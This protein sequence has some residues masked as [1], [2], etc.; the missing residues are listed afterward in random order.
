MVSAADFGF[1]PGSEADQ[2]AALQKAADAAAARGLPL[3][4]PGGTYRAGDINLTANVTIYGVDGAT[5]IINSGAAPIFHADGQSNITL[6][7]LSLDG[8]GGGP[9]DSRSGLIAFNKCELLRL[10]AIDLHQ[11]PGNGLFLSG[12]SGLVTGSHFGGHA[13]VGIFAIDSHELTISQNQVVDCGNGGILVWQSQSGRDGTIVSG[14]H[15]ARIAAKAGGNGQNGNG[16]NIFRADNVIVADNVIENCDFSAIRANTTRNTSIRGNTCTNLSETGIYSEFAFSGSVIA[17]NIVDGAAAGIS[18]TNLDQGGRL[19][20]CSGN[21]VRNILPK[22]PTN[23]DSGPVGISAQADTAVTGNTVSNVPGV[24]INAGYGPY[25]RNVII[26]DNVISEIDTAI[27]VSVAPG[28]GPVRIA[29]NMIS[30]ARVN[31]IIGTEW[32]KLSSADL[33]ADA[34][35]FPNVSIEGNIVGP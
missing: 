26:A 34:A 29:G 5:I 2:S 32:E 3:F 30:G 9:M 10:D 4:L 13:D 28:A 17:N 24:G 8:T 31:A 15:I 22:S 25:V 19:A 1:V 27:D 12:C 6:R 14:N 20:V 21:I 18:I 35:Q 16:I 23:P 11:G 7:S 33:A